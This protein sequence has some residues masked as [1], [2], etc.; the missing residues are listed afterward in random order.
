M[1]YI[2][3]IGDSRAFMSIDKGSKIFKLSID[4]KPNEEGER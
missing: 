4:H 3:N 1:C 2:G